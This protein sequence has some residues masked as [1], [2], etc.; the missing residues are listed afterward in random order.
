MIAL[1]L[2][3]L[4]FAVFLA[5]EAYA[6]ALD[7]LS[8]I[9]LRGLL[10]EE[11]RRLRLFSSR[12][13]VPA[14]KIALRVVIQILLLVGFWTVI[15]S[16]AAFAVPSSGIWGALLFF[17]GWL[18]AEA[19]LLRMVSGTAP[20]A[21]LVRLDPLVAALSWIL[22]PIAWPIRL[23]FRARP[24]EDDDGPASDEEVQAYIDV[25]RE[26]GILEGEDE[27]LLQSIVDFGETMVKEVMTPRTDIAAVE[28]SASIERAADIFI[29]TKY[30]RLPVYRG[31]IDQIVGIVHVKDVFE[32]VR[33]ES[34]SRLSDVARPV[35]FV[36]ET[37]RTAEL[38]REFQRKRLAMTIVVDEYGSVAGLVT[39]EDLLEEIVG[40]IS[41]EH[42]D[43]RDAVLKLADGAYSISGRAHMDVLQETFGHG[44][45]EEDFDSLGGYLAARMGRIPRVGEKREEDGLRFTVEEGDRRRVLRVRVE[46]VGAM[47]ER[48][49]QNA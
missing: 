35:T 9:K 49:E 39:I 26:E 7:R 29:E 10:E 4:C 32:K 12:A 6:Q 41:D 8:P 19:L 46:P 44:P 45:K 30:S 25:G 22:A 5:F 28:E 24:G 34:R 13:E 1:A 31:T 14:V 2:A 37:K 47:P 40:E 16:L 18:S 3:A 38:L 21:V 42:E 48:K 36:P 23:L 17:V 20:E 33:R 11:P 27:K 43:E 15:R